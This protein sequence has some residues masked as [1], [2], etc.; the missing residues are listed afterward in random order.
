MSRIV[1]VILIYRR[2]KPI[3]SIVYFYLIASDRVNRN[4]KSVASTKCK[5]HV[6][7]LFETVLALINI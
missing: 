4:E 7:V 3:D 6:S 5:V 2:H 1:V